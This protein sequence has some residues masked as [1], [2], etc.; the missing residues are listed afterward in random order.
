MAGIEAD[1]GFPHRRLRG[2]PWQ[3]PPH[4]P[5]KLVVSRVQLASEE[6][7]H[8]MQESQ[9][10]SDRR[11]GSNQYPWHHRKLS[12]VK[13]PFVAKARTKA[14]RAGKRLIPPDELRGGG[15]AHG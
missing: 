2:D 9:N 4:L 5:F 12:P 1:P 13:H 6:R 3:R 8:Q 7:V 10:E 14:V 11:T 15:N